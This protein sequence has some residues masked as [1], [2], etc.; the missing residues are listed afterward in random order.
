MAPDVKLSRVGFLLLEVRDLERSLAFYRDGLGLMV[1]GSSGEFA[2]LDG[3]GVT[4][5]LR[6]VPRQTAPGE[7]PAV[8]VVFAVEDIDA[9]HRALE[10]RGVEFRVPPRLVSGD[11]LAAD[12]R[13]PDGHVLSIFGPRAPATAR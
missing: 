13:D 10:R 6:P 7:R 8:E 1:K 11:Q 3:G 2:F 5:G 9:A 12:F 4:L